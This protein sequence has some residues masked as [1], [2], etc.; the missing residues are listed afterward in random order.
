MASSISYL[1]S[2]SNFLQVSPEVPITKARNPEKVDSP[3]VFEGAW[4]F[5]DI[6]ASIDAVFDTF[7][8]QTRTCFRFDVQGQ[9][10]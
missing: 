5:L 3:D 8:Q 2:R 1:T 9:T 10:S 6:S 7:S 4:P